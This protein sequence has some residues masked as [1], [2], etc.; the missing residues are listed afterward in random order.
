MAFP[1]RTSARSRA[2]PCDRCAA[3]G[4]GSVA[5]H[6]HRDPRAKALT[7]LWSWLYGTPVSF[8]SGPMKRGSRVH[9]LRRD[10]PLSW[11]HAALT[12]TQSKPRETHL[13]LFP[14]A[15]PSKEEKP[16]GLA[17]SRPHPRPAGRAPWGPSLP[18]V[19]RAAFSRERQPRPAA[20]WRLPGTQAARPGR[21]VRGRP[22]SSLSLLPSFLL[23]RAFGVRGVLFVCF[24]S[25][26]A[27]RWLW[28]QGPGVT[29]GRPCPPTRA[30]P[31]RRSR[32][33]TA[34]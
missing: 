18:G 29:R 33:R 32:S 4:R 20:P 7:V 23:C 13:S 2:R 21:G 27:R 6:Q 10:C 9:L 25:R 1:G 24:C 16:G 31:R 15:F 26:R 12:T 17:A 11:Q 28:L 5:H 30:E 22:G 8:S 3:T 34:K 19:P 14:V